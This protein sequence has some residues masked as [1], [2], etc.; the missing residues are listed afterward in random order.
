[1]LFLNAGEDMNQE[2]IQALGQLA[3]LIEPIMEDFTWYFIKIYVFRRTELIRNSSGCS[4]QIVRQRFEGNRM[5]LFLDNMNQLVT[6]NEAIYPKINMT[7]LEVIEF[8]ET[9]VAAIA[10]V[11][12]IFHKHQF[13]SFL[14]IFSIKL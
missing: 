12:I 10:T 13:F 7:A 8:L 11:A 1:M 9:R 4:D 2:K 3:R 6:N 5:D 14:L